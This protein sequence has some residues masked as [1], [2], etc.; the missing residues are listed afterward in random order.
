MTFIPSNIQRASFKLAAGLFHESTVNAFSFHV[1]REYPHWASTCT[2]LQQMCDLWKIV[3]VKSRDVGIHKNDDLRKPIFSNDDLRLRILREYHSFFCKWR[4]SHGAGLTKEIFTACEV[5]YQ[6]L[7]LFCEYLMDNGF[8]YVLLGHCQSD[9]I[10]H[11]FGLYRQ[12]S[13]SN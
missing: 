12:M 13:G 11:R 7:S 6:T 8:N 9:A 1:S 2:F 3:N 4:N 10:E 5:M